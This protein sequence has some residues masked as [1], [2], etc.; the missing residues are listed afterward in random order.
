MDSILLAHADKNALNIIRA[1]SNGLMSFAHKFSEN[2]P[3]HR[4]VHYAKGVSIF[5]KTLV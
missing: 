5:Y 1:S 4:A 2:T 3:S